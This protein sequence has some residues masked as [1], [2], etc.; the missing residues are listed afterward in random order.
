MLCSF[1]LS[2]LLLLN[3]CYSVPSTVHL[4]SSLAS[5]LILT[6]H[7]LWIIICLHFLVCPFI[8]YVCFQFVLEPSSYELYL[9]PVSASFCI[10]SFPSFKSSFFRLTYIFA[11]LVSFEFP[12][13]IISFVNLTFCFKFSYVL[14]YYCVILLPMWSRIFL[15][16]LSL[17]NHTPEGANPSCQ[18]PLTYCIL[19]PIDWLTLFFFIASHSFF[20]IACHLDTLQGVLLLGL[21]RSLFFILPIIHSWDK[22]PSC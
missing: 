8:H 4:L 14:L 16:F 2:G 1:P 20:V 9:L 21:S 3:I 18:S 22:F 15:S 17:V 5:S 7:V 10:T 6:I 19:L 12:S 13:P 11:V